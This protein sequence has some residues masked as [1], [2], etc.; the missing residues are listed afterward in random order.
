MIKQVL[1]F[2]GDYPELIDKIDK[3]D[4]PTSIGKSD[5]QYQ[6]ELD[7]F[8]EK[9]DEVRNDIIKAL[10]G[11][12]KIK[13]LPSGIAFAPDGKKRFGAEIRT[14]DDLKNAIKGIEGRVDL[15]IFDS[16]ISDEFNDSL[17]IQD[18]KLM[19]TEV[20]GDEE[21]I[22]GSEETLEALTDVIRDEGGLE[23][24]KTEFEAGDTIKSRTSFNL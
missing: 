19:F 8:K 15:K 24:Q 2:T 5:A 3:L 9:E 16:N 4:P 7:A 14:T 1:N 20:F 10:T 12:S 6:K 22:T 18:G 23:V 13:K 21:E 11:K 17:Y